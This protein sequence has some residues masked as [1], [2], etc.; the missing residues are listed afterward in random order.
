MIVLLR[1]GAS[2]ADEDALLARIH[3]LGLTAVPLDGPRGRGLEVLGAGLGQALALRDSPAVHEILTR[4]TALTGGEPLWPHFALRLSIAAILLLTALCLLAAWLPPGLGDPAGG[5]AV[6]E[7]VTV[8]WYMRPAAGLLGLLPGGA[9]PVLSLAG[10]LAWGLLFFWPW[11]D[12][13]E[14][15]TPGRRRALR[16][17]G[18]AVVLALCALGALA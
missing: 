13:P 10:L 5:G 4:R 8:E 7:G 2:R 16:L 15:C 1:A 6:A 12:R 9:R 17:L 11:I 3:E 14:R 18:L